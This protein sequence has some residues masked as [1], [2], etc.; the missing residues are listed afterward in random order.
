M[1]E[2]AGGPPA[3][4][5]L[6]LAIA[7]SDRRPGCDWLL[8]AQRRRLRGGPPGD[9]AAM[10]LARRHG[11]PVGRITAHRQRAHRPPESAGAGDSDGDGDSE[12]DSDG[13]RDSDGDG[14]D[15]GEGVGSFGFLVIGGPE[16]HDVASALLAAAAAWL[17]QRGCATLLGPVS[18][19]STEEAG[20][21]VA[22][23]DGPPVTGR[24]WT[25]PWYPDAL[26]AA[27]LEAADELL[28]YRLPAADDRQPPGHGHVEL[29]PADFVV[30]AEIGRFADPALLLA[31]PGDR[32]SVVAVPDIAGGL[33]A[34]GRR[35]VRSREAWA[36]AR[37]ARRRAW[38][39]CVVIGLD[40][41]EAELIPALCVAAGRA[42][43]SWVLSP[44]APDGR[45]P[46]M[47][48]RLYRGEVASLVP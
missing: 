48:H 22:G 18:W 9:E 16:D 43:Y 46:V 45:P 40:G 41:P 5:L 25:P 29:V 39:S 6:D 7:L 8:A 17:H 35:G 28:T 33:A 31:A 2:V 15:D 3:R 32:G 10:F 47:R 19:T 34:D 23:H 20:L 1:E 24:A 26:V 36:I 42:G 11:Q 27:G 30:P 12:G 44:W 13:A 14:V 37:R 4:E 38:S 21:L